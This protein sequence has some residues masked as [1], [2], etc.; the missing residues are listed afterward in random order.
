M[1][2]ILSVYLTLEVLLHLLVKHWE[3]SCQPDSSQRGELG[4]PWQLPFPSSQALDN[5]HHTQGFLYA[6]AC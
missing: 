1:M 3:T 2:G 4:Q 5:P 6:A